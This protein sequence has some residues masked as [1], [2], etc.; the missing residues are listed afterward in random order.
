MST[1]FTKITQ[2]EKVLL[3]KTITHV[4]QQLQTPELADTFIHRLLTEKERL[5]ISRRLLIASMI[6]RGETYMAIN[7]QLSISPNTFTKIK[8]WL[9]EELPNYDTVLEHTQKATRERART[10]QDKTKS[11]STPFTYKRLKNTYPAHF[12]LFNI[13]EELFKK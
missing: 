6:Q 9:E 7:N 13:T 4:G 10:K 11:Y 1:N 5:Q 12:L 2:S 8:K 3:E